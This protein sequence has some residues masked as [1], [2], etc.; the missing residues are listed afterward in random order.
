M[1]AVAPGLAAEM[2]FFS[3]EEAKWIAAIMNQIVP[4]DDRPGAVE[5]GCLHYLDRQLGSALKRFVIPYRSGLKAFQLKEP[6]FL[7]MS[8]SQ[9]IE[10]LQKM[11]REP[12]FEMLVDHTMQGFYGSPEHGGNR[13]EASWKMMGIE[14]Y[15]GGGHWHGA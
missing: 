3:P 11:D 5:A 1:A 14:K 15:M 4:A 6:K 8:S 12:F 9:Q 7:E 2:K 13:D 10:A